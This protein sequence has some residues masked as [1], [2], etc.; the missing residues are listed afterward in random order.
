[1]LTRAMAGSFGK[2][3]FLPGT[4]RPKYG[5]A[6]YQVIFE[7][8][9]ALA[10]GGDPDG[11][12]AFADWVAERRVEHEQFEPSPPWQGGEPDARQAAYLATMFDGIRQDL[13]AMGKDSGR[14]TAVCN[15]AMH[16]GNFIAGAGLNEVAAR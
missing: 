16:C 15:K 9:D 4:Q 12:E 2:L 14:N 11:A 7:D 5:G 1:M 3:V 13:S 8:L 10:D 6:G